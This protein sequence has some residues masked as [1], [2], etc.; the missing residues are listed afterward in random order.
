MSGSTRF[1]PITWKPLNEAKRRTGQRCSGDTP[2]WRTPWP[3]FSP[4]RT[5]FTT[6]RPSSA[7]P[8]PEAPTLAPEPLAPE[9]LASPA[10]LGT[11]RYFGDYELLEEVARGG[12]GVVYKARQVSLNRVVAIKMILAGQLAG[13]ADVRR[14]RAEAQTAAGLQ[15]PHIVAIHEV[16][17]HQG[18][19]YF[20]MDFVEGQSLADRIAGGPL[21]P[22]QAARYVEVVARAIQ[23]AHE[24]GVLHRDLKASNILL[25]R[26][27]RPRVT[28]FGLARQITTDKGLTTSGAVLG[29]PSYM[30]PDQATGQRD[31][32]GPAS[33]VYS[34]G[35]VLYELVTGRPPFRAA[36]PLD[37]LLQVLEAEPAP[38]EPGPYRPPLPRFFDPHGN[39]DL[40]LLASPGPLKV[41]AVRAATGE[42]L[43]ETAVDGPDDSRR[44]SGFH[45][46]GRPSD[47]P[48]P[49]ASGHARPQD[50]LVP[51]RVPD[52][53]G[54][55]GNRD[56]PGVE[57][58]DGRTGKPVWRRHLFREEGW[59]YRDRF[60]NRLLVGPD[61]D[62]DGQPELLGAGSVV[63]PEAWEANKN[64]IRSGAADSYY[65]VVAALSGADGRLL[66]RTRVPESVP[67]SNDLDRIHWGP[68]GADGRPQLVFSFVNRFNGAESRAW[69]F[70]AATGTQRHAVRG[71]EA[72]GTADFDG[73]GLPDLYGFRPSIAKPMTRI[74]SDP[75]KLHVFRVWSRSRCASSASGAWRR[76]SPGKAGAPCTSPAASSPRATAASCGT[77]RPCP[78]P[79]RRPTSAIT[80]T[81]SRP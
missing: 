81:S 79:T 34:L 47:W 7:P 53:S 39:G 43:W 60:L 77:T 23:Y 26:E 11:V 18:Q 22:M 41:R 57:R 54:R 1:S 38:V 16:G 66:W 71:L 9:P 73:D 30:P 17:E 49:I 13:E 68:P 75:G 72:V 78:G 64:S 69:V 62:G 59:Q 58:L 80:I 45:W 32:L 42:T 56:W 46:V 14:F 40:A 50:L 24:R 76:M 67:G 28:D 36:T 20:S 27:D 8:Y 21:P 6:P 37:T 74:P 19:H 70:D 3:P 35:A 15:H 33:D 5:A 10:P 29:T 63:D 55:S 2:T 25:D 51:F 65:P 61:L 44:T 4:T 12:M 48:L 52:S 31:Q